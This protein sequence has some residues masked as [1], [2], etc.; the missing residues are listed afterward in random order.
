MT[1][2][3]YLILESK[4]RLNFNIIP[5]KRQNFFGTILCLRELTYDVI[6]SD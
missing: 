5:I 2:Q 6:G 4:W 3:F 1:R